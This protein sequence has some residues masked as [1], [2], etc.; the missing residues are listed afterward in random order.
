MNKSLCKYKGSCYPRATSLSLPN[1]PRFSGLGDPS[2]M[3]YFSVHYWLIGELSTLLIPELQNLSSTVKGELANTTLVQASR[4]CLPYV[5]GVLQDDGIA[6]RIDGRQWRKKIALICVETIWQIGKF[7]GDVPCYCRT[8]GNR[9]C[10]LWLD[11]GPISINQLGQ[12]AV[13]VLGVITYMCYGT[14]RGAF[15]LLP[16]FPLKAPKWPRS[17]VQGVDNRAIPFCC[18]LTFPAC[19]YLVSLAGSPWQ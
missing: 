1:T 10:G 16:Y 19:S 11:V 5:F 12:V 18:S 9:A 7:G 3:P 6:D 17:V 15:C 4:D 8:I 2:K 14:T 13:R